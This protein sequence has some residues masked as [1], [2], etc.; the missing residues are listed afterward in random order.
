MKRR[1]LNSEA[2][3]VTHEWYINAVKELSCKKPK[4]SRSKRSA[5]QPSCSKENCD[6]EDSEADADTEYP[7]PKPLSTRI[8]MSKVAKA[9]TCGQQ[10]SG[11]ASAPLPFSAPLRIGA[12]KAAKTSQPRTP[13]HLFAKDYVVVK[14]VPI[15]KRN[16]RALFYVGSIVSGSVIEG[17]AVQC[18]KR[19]GSSSNQFI[20]PAPEAIEIYSHESI[21]C[22]LKTPKVVNTVYHFSEDFSSF[23]LALR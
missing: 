16:S 1:K 18:M 9:S 10:A 8:R 7:S 17:W 4:P 21:V 5:A 12:A 23:A 19:Q 20:Y 3:V 14:R 22:V 2:A 11:S 6:G 13:L 15:G